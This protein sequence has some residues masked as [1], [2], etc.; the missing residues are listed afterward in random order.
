LALK[1]FVLIKYVPSGPF[2][3]NVTAVP[4]GTF[5]EFGVIVKGGLLLIFERLPLENEVKQG[6]LKIL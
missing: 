2:T 6:I 1:L 5:V 3:V 4:S